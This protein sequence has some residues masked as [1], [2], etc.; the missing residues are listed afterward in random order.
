MAETEQTAAHAPQ[1]LQFDLS[2]NM[3]I[4]LPSFPAGTGITVRHLFHFIDLFNIMT[5]NRFTVN[6]TNNRIIHKSGR[7]SDVS[8]MVIGEYRG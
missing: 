6:I 2:V 5:G 4:I 1:P 3:Q 7:C 8:A